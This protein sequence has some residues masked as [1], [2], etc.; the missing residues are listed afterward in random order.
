MSQRQEDER[1]SVEKQQK[2]NAC[3]ILFHNCLGA[4]LELMRD[5]LMQM[6]RFHSLAVILHLMGRRT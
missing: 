6:M 4:L 5:D 3:H 1:V 2:I